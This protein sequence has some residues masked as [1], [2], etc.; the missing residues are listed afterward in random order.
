MWQLDDSM[1]KQRPVQV[2]GP[3]Y[4]MLRGTLQHSIYHAGQLSLLRGK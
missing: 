2:R 4:V 1:L 3:F